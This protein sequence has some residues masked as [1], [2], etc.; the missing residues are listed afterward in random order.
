MKKRD[1][2]CCFEE[3]NGLDEKFITTTERH[4]NKKC[5]GVLEKNQRK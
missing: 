1:N 3:E 5:K 4:S 2:S